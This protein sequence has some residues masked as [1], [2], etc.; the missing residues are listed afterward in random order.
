METSNNQREQDSQILA[1]R[2][3]QVQKGG[4]RASV[5]GVN[6]GLVSVL[7]LIVGVA[8]AGGDNNAVLVAGFAG[9]ISGA[10]SMAAGEWISV[11]SQV[12]LFRGVLKDLKKLIRHDKQLLTETLAEH[13]EENGYTKKTAAAATAELAKDDQ[14]FFKAYSTQVIGLNPDELGSPWVSS[15]SSFVLFSAGALAPLLPWILSG[16]TTALVWSLI[17]TALG[18]LITGAYVANSSGRSIWF[19]ASRQLIIIALASAVTY[20]IGLLFGVAVS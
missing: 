9:L 1:K 17:L 12:D 4:A 2:A 10:F 13:M 11:Q 14:E 15:G 16:G 20:G 19:G 5:L 6:D 18:G 7:C 3:A 8:G